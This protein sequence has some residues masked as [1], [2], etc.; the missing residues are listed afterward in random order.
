MSSDEIERLTAERDAIQMLA[1]DWRVRCGWAR[2]EIET[3][4]AELAAAYERCAKQAEIKMRKRDL[5][6]ADIQAVVASIRALL[7]KGGGD[8]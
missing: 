1:D 3:L 6:E 7:N 5:R 2:S 4:R 8:E